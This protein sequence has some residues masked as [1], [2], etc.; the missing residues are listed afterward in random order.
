MWIANFSLRL[1]ADVEREAARDRAA[2]R[3]ARL[4]AR[5]AEAA[6]PAD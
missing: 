2:K 6:A 3:K 5:E 4:K 1:L